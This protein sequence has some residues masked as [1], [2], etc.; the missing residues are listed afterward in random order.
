MT[1]LREPRHKLDDYMKQT[2]SPI[3]GNEEY[4]DTLSNYLAFG[5]NMKLTAEHLH[6]H[7][8]TLKYRLSKI[9]E[10]LQCDL[11]DAN[12]RFRLRM[13]ITI[14]QYLQD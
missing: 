4:I 3:L 10:T 6:I 9:S 13:V 12:V 11:K 14:Y 5:E 7:I 2:L 1:L 8:N